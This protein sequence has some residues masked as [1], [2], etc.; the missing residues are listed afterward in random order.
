MVKVCLVRQASLSIQLAGI[1]NG[2]FSIYSKEEQTED[3]INI[4]GATSQSMKSRFAEM[5]DDESFVG[6]P[7]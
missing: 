7:H 6:L 2:Q 5:A 3:D 4:K 1:N